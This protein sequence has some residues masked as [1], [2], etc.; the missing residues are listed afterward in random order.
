MIIYNWRLIEFF[1]IQNTKLVV[2]GETGMRVITAQA[3]NSEKE[4]TGYSFVHCDISGTGT[5]TFLGRAWMTR[6]KVVFSYTTM[7]KV[8]HP[9]GWSEN[10]QAER[11]G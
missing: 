7:T 8:I 5:A 9:L 6:P 10:L 2:V 3:R 1:D 4:D 11:A